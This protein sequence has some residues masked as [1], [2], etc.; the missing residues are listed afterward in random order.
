MKNRNKYDVS[1]TLP[2]QKR[3]FGGSTVATSDLI[4]MLSDD[5]KTVKD[6]YDSVH[7]DQEAKLI[8]KK[9]IDTGYKDF[10]MKDFLPSDDGKL[11]TCYRKK[12][13]NGVIKEIKIADL[14]KESKNELRKNNYYQNEKNEEMELDI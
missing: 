1:W 8:L 14:N 10:I 5:K 6:V 7:Y 4:V 11:R 2:G 13:S 9:F 3:P 12:E